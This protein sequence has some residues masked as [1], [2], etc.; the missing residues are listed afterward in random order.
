[1]QKLIN[2]VISQIRDGDV[3][4]LIEELEQACQVSSEHFVASPFIHFL[5]QCL[6]P[7]GSTG[8][9]IPVNPRMI[10]SAPILEG[11]VGK[12]LDGPLR[13]LCA[14]LATLINDA[15]ELYSGKSVYVLINKAVPKMD[16]KP[17]KKT[18]GTRWD[19]VFDQRTRNK[20]A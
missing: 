6:Y 17:M 8:K 20:R 5:T 14:E 13:D 15:I 1:M 10:A 19:S 2:T 12:L 11:K 16:R 4:S 3:L 7:A 9:R 18:R